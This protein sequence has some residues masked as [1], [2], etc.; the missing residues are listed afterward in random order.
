MQIRQIMLMELPYLLRTYSRSSDE[1]IMM[2]YFCQCCLSI[3][4]HPEREK[5]YCSVLRVLLSRHITKKGG[6]KKVERIV[7]FCRK[8]PKQ[9]V[10][11]AKCSESMKNMVNPSKNDYFKPD[12]FIQTILPELEPLSE[13]K[14]AALTLVLESGTV[15]DK[16]K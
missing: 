5:Y 14:L 7:K 12:S 3:F 16:Q 6:L 8:H 10:L 2:E 1:K 13:D 9:A 15:I 11:Y 4:E